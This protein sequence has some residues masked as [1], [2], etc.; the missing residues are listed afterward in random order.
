[1]SSKS[2]RA[3]S[4]EERGKSE[5]FEVFSLWCLVFCDAQGVTWLFTLGWLILMTL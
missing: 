5:E 3:K 4:K 1:M 2:Q